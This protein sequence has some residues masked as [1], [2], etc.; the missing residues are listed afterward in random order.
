MIEKLFP[1]I[2]RVLCLVLVRGEG[3]V[4]LAESVDPAKL[5]FAL[6]SRFLMGIRDEGPSLLRW[7]RAEGGASVPDQEK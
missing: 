7:R 5:Q 3:G 2:S 1:H 6:R 4:S